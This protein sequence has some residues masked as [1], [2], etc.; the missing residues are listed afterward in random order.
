MSAA[1]LAELARARALK[2]R[3]RRQA[4]ARARAQRR[5]GKRR[6][7]WF[8][9]AILAGAALALSGCAAKVQQP[10]PQVVLKPC[11]IETPQRP[12]MPTED[13]QS[14]A[15]L[16]DFVKSAIAEIERRE[17]YERLLLQSL[18][19]CKSGVMFK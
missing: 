7:G 3:R 12:I 18:I 16:D 19:F 1:K 13:L 2:L 6:G 8:W 14:D 4:A 11:S 9:A 5:R 15:T 10:A 17:G